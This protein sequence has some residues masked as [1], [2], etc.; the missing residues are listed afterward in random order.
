[1]SASLDL[2]RRLSVGDHGLAIVSTTRSDGSV[3]SSL[4]NA[5]L[6]DDPLTGRPA[7]GFVSRGD[8][9]K[10][11]LIRRVGRAVLAFR[12]GWEYVAVEGP[13]TLFGPEDLPS[14]YDAA[15]I[16]QLLRDVFTAAGGTH[17]DWDAYDRVMADEG[18]LAVLV[19]PGRITA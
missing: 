6:L 5:G 3:H 11:R 13:V 10:V 15:Q 8:A 12:V 1:M 7:I 18:R 9:T 4:V 17:D 19:E 2:V 14:G 16:P